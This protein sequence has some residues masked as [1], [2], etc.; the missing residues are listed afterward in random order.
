MIRRILAGALVTLTLA[1]ASLADVVVLR[2]Q[3]RFHGTLA[4]RE[5][6]ARNVRSFASLALLTRPAAG[7]SVPA[8]VRFERRDVS[9]VILEDGA[10]QRVFDL[11]LG[12]PSRPAPDQVRPP[13]SRISSVDS[14]A[15][16][17]LDSRR[18]LGP[19]LCLL[20]AGLV[21][22]GVAVKFGTH[23]TFLGDV[24]YYTGGNYACMWVGGAMFVTG[25]IAM[26]S[27]PAYAATPAEP[28]PRLALTCRF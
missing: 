14:W 5:E 8:L 1:Q 23:K 6:F 12:P 11:T 24:N 28:G 2:N 3:Q 17:S 16:P 13:A 27:A 22:V 9:H 21:A 15:P 19:P 10:E 20:G 26:G 18:T 7:D 4:N 25:V